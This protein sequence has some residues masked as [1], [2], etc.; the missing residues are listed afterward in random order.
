[1][2]EPPTKRA[3]HSD[4]AATRGDRNHRA[5]TDTVPSDSKE[6]QNDSRNGL[7][8]GNRANDATRRRSRSPKRRKDRQA[9]KRKRSRSPRAEDTGYRD[10]DNGRQRDRQHDSSRS[11]KGMIATYHLQTQ[12][13][14]TYTCKDNHR[15]DRKRSRS[16]SRS[17]SRSPHRNGAPSRIPAGDGG[18]PRSQPSE[19]KPGSGSS[20]AAGS[21]RSVNRASNGG[22]MDVDDNSVDAMLKTMMGFSSFKSTQNT[23]VPGNQIYGVRKEKKSEYRQYMNR[24]G[25]FNRPLSPGR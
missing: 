6:K 19:R 18:H 14:V 20:S 17:R 11:I 2:D 9:A 24:V 21:S 23:K 3:R 4:G 15:S 12:D 16:P 8:V 1:M 13:N 25:G 5:A 22:D 10:R 7:S